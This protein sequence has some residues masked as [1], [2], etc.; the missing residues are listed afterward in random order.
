MAARGRRRLNWDKDLQ[1]PEIVYLIGSLDRGG[2][3]LHLARIAPKLIEKGWSVTIVCLSRRGSLAAAV[4]RQGVR[5]LSA[6][7]EL[8]PTIPRWIRFVMLGV[9]AARFFL[10]VLYRRPFAVHMFL[11]AAYW[12]G[13]PI[14]LLAGIRRR[15][16]SRRSR[17]HYLKRLFVA[18]R[19]ERFLH[20]RMTFVLGN[21]QKV[22]ADLLEEGASPTQTYLIYNGVNMTPC[23][24][25]AAAV[26][27]KKR[28]ELGLR[29]E[30]VI[31]CVAN[32]I[33]YKG[34]AD[35]I[36]AMALVQNRVPSNWRLLI[37]GRDDGI[38]ANLR[39][40]AD[41]AGVGEAIRFLGER[42]DAEELLAA[43]DLFVLPSHEEGFS[44]ALIE[45]MSS[46]LAVVATD[47]GGNAEAVE[48]GTSGL[49]VP[50]RSPQA[51]ADAVATML[52]D[53]SLRMTFGKAARARAE[54]RFSLER[55][56][57][58]YDRLYRSLQ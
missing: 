15:L 3:E 21:S 20:R 25:D 13:G 5:L 57:D 34:H 22:V 2:A 30:L 23:T 12:I 31:V 7:V 8:R 1:R 56:V 47:V 4:E 32:L 10:Y 36:D 18:R 33:P 39:S 51:L 48:S 44:N 53:K 28:G 35:L 55:C 52:Q 54:Q 6:P 43:S 45:A 16:M 9:S 38:G 11:P 14:V 17:N 26:R 41:A 50:S 46:G 40:R 49:I 27:S 24:G 37:V 19:L 29:D 42:S 58:E